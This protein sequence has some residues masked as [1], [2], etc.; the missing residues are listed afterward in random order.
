MILPFYDSLISKLIFWD[1]TRSSAITRFKCTLEESILEWPKQTS[2]CL[3]L[4]LMNK[5]FARE[6]SIQNGLRAG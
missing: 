4:W 6:I 2:R 3:K 5:T 1:E